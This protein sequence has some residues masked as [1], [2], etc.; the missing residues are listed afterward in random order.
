MIIFSQ[1][2]KTMNY[3]N[4]KI[5]IKEK[6]FSIDEIASQINMTREGLT[7]SLN[8]EKLKIDTLEKICKILGVSPAIF[9]EGEKNSTTIQN[10]G[11][12]LG[13]TIQIAL[14]DCEKELS[15]LREQLAE[16]KEEIA[17]LREML[18]SKT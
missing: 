1:Y 10:S 9:F 15:H 13:N 3:S 18:K 6:K 12:G 7:R 4:L 17:F 2:H 11:N 14:S 5:L 8:E 16:K